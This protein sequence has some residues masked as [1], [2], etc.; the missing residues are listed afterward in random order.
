MSER[1]WEIAAPKKAPVQASRASQGAT[2]GLAQVHAN[3]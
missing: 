2:G 1:T 3:I